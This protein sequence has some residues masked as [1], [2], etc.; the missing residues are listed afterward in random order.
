MSCSLKSK[1]WIFKT[2]YIDWINYAA[3]FNYTLLSIY[4]EKWIKIKSGY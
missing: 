1:F 3:L 4:I 2:V